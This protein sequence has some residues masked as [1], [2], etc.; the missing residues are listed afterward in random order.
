MDFI[1]IKNFIASKDS[2]ERAE[3]KLHNGRVLDV[4]QISDKGSR[5]RIYIK[6]HATQQQKSNT[7]LQKWA[8]DLNQHL[9]KADLQIANG[10]VKRQTFNLSSH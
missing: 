7:P 10:H 5:Y 6:T 2:T 3:V 8:E 4:N 1:K 9:S